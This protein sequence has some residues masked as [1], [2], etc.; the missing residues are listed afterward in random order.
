VF[1]KAAFEDAVHVGELVGLDIYR[2]ALRASA[3]A[4]QAQLSGGCASL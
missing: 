1:E 3:A 4:T 2:V